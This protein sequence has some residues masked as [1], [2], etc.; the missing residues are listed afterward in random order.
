MLSVSKTLVVIP[1]LNEEAHLPGLL[2]ALLEEPDDFRVAVVD[3]GSQDASRRIVSDFSS[4]DHR[5]CLIDNPKRTQAPG[6]NLAAQLLGADHHWLVRMDAHAIYQRDYVRRLVETA[7]RL[8]GSSIVVPMTTHGVGCFQRAVA[9]AQN[10]WLGTG[11]ARHRHV[12]VGGWVD[13]G[14]HALFNLRNFLM[15]SG[16]NEAFS[17]NEDAEFDLR[18]SKAGIKIWLEPS[19]V[20]SYSPRST[21]ASLAKQYYRFGIGRFKTLE[22]HQAKPLVRQML[23]LLAWFEEPGL[24]R[25]LIRRCCGHHA[26]GVVGRVL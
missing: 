6:I 2:N 21:P 23:P 1:C 22:L 4:R 15:L 7:T 14:H 11:G 12:S 3:G 26:L 24:L 20:V 25:V 13:H 18:Q 19:L 10:S 16:Y 5:V 8:E 9:A 17:H